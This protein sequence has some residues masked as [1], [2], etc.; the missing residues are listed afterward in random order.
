MKKLLVAVAAAVLG[1]LA[2]AAGPA[3][4]DVT[5]CHDVQININGESVADAACNTLP[6]QG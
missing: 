1:T 3:S 2:L 6:P 5:V 4:A